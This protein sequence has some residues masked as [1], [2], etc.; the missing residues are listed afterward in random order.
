MTPFEILATDAPFDFVTL[1]DADL[2]NLGLTPAEIADAIE[3]AI[4]MQ[5]AGQ[6]HAPP[7]SGVLPGDGR[8]VMTTL[9]TGTTDDP[10]VVKVVSLQ[11]KNPARG[12]PAINGAILVLD[13]ETGLLRAV[14]GANWITAVRTAGMSAVIA[15][16]LANPLAKSIAFLGCGVQARAHL[17]AFSDLFPLSDL[18]AF[19]RGQ[20][21]IDRLCAAASA[22]GLDTR[23]AATPEDAMAG[24]DIVV[25]A[26]T[27]TAGMAPFVDARAL[28]PGAFAAITDVALPW[29][30]EGLAALDTVIIDDIAQ[31]AKMDPPMVAPDLVTGDMRSLVTGRIAAGYDSAK[32]AALIFRGQAFG[33]YAIAALALARATG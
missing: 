13:G 26:I 9:S 3:D 12:L 15:K 16:R 7:K 24:A 20:T 5:A 23:T 33:D 1:S 4:R 32:R 6:L 18:V 28:K 22:L 2:A 31:E 21:N 11:P 10:T 19:G 29:I 17:A 25:S 27:R 14:M 30:P 8:Y